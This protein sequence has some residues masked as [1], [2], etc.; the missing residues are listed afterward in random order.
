MAFGDGRPVR[1][2]LVGFGYWGPNYAKSMASVEGA[3]LA[4]CADPSE[5]A[6]RR[7]AEALPQARLTRNFQELI[8]ADDCDAV[9]VAVPTSVHASVAHAALDAGK[10]LL[11]E[12]PLSDRYEAASALARAARERDAIAVTGHLYLF[13]PA[14][15]T[16]LERVRSG[17]LGAL[18]YMSA[19]RMAF[20]PIRPDVDALWDLA[21]HDITMFLSFANAEPIRVYAAQTA[22]MRAD[23]A[24]AVFATLEFP[25][26]VIASLQVSWDYP[27]RERLIRI[28]GSRETLVLD[29]TAPSEKLLA[30]RAGADAPDNR[31]GT[32]AHPPYAPD[33][34]LVEQVRHFV[35]C[36][37]RGVRSPIDFELGARLV[38]VLEALTESATTHRP[39]EL[40]SAVS[41]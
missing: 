22:Y 37:R 12:K 8:D 9:I 20:S 31:D 6:L 36:V 14:V 34:P 41:Q 29:D 39:V 2:G 26:G 10:P 5:A 35:D 32:I 38:R 18:R 16:M 30:Y 40:L 25:G 24:D 33:Q 15:R 7:A 23:R 28:V 1:L 27:F 21:P 17:E 19:S 3:E 13:N 4:W 11:V